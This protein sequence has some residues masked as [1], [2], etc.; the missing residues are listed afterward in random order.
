MNGHAASTALDPVISRYLA[1]RRALG[2]QYDHEE[3]TLHSL[4]DFLVMGGESD[5]TSELFESWCRTFE[6]LNA[7]GRRGRQVAVRNFCLYRQRTEP[8]CFV[9]DINR[10]AR[11]R[12]YS[13]PV[14]LTPLQVSQL[15]DLADR[16]EATATSPLR[17]YV[18]SVALVLLFTAGLRRRELVRL[19][20]ADV[21]AHAG[22]LRVREF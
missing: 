19:T 14:I 6:L 5:L 4:T 13:A 10:F 15:L 1:L 22:V 21:D 20:L 7:N 2:R 18:L 11:T 17:P 9:P 8:Q 3:R 16:R 12:P